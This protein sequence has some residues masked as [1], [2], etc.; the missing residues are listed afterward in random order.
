MPGKVVTIDLLNWFWVVNES[1]TQVYSSKF[2]DYINVSN[3]QY[4]AWLALGNKPIAIKT[5]FDLG[6]VLAAVASDVTR[7]VPLGVLDGF[8]DRSAQEIYLRQLFRMIFNHENRLRA[9]ERFNNMP[10]A[11]PD[12]TKQEAKQWVKDQM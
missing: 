12:L 4:Q 1:T 7:P 8:Q 5:E 6:S 11:K 3:A 9:I 2:G 10:G